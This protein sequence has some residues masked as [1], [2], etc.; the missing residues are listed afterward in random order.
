LQVNQLKKAREK[1]KLLTRRELAAVMDV[2]M[3]TITKWERDGLPIAKRGRKGKPSLYSE[4]DVRAWVAAREQAA[5]EPAGPLD[6]AQERA[7]R[8]HWQALLSQQLYL[9]RA[10]KLLPV[11]EVEKTWTEHIVGPRS[12]ILSLPT[13]A[14][15]VH[16]SS[17]LHGLAGVEAELR[18]LS[19]EILRELAGRPPKESTT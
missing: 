18:A 1:Q 9:V 2:H 12:L 4:D 11:E 19:H 5:S 14:D 6:W 17:T 10:K 16:R 7:K 3:M 8:E 15:R 13:A